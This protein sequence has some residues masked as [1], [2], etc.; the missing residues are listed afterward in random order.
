MRRFIIASAS[1]LAL[2]SAQAADF[3]IDY[4]DEATLDAVAQA[5]TGLWVPTSV[6]PDGQTIPGHVGDVRGMP[7]VGEWAMSQPFQQMAPTGQ[8]FV[9]AYGN[10]R[11]IIAPVGGWSRLFR[12]NA[13]VAGL[14]PYIALGGG[15]L[16]T[17]TDP[18]TGGIITT[19]TAGP[20]TMTSPPPP[21]TQLSF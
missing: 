17:T 4:P 15:T 11:P 6:G 20:V 3:R 18:T 2:S 10:T 5:I 9:D 13:D 7:G 19:I 16:T 8:T 1:T 12:W 14:T 21:G